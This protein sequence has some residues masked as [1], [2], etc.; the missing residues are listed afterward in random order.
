V[1]D[2]ARLVDNMHYV[3]SH[4]LLMDWASQLQRCVRASA[5]Y[6]RADAPV[7]RGTQSQLTTLLVEP[8]SQPQPLSA[9]C[10]SAN[11]GSEGRALSSPE[12]SRCPRSAP[13]R[14]GRASNASGV[15]GPVCVAPCSWPE[16]TLTFRTESEHCATVRA[17]SAP[18]S[19]HPCF[20]PERTCPPCPA[21]PPAVDV[22]I[23]AGEPAMADAQL[24][25]LAYEL[26]R[27]TWRASRPAR[28][29]WGAPRGGCW[30]SWDSRTYISHDR[31]WH[32]QAP[33]DVVEGACSF[34]WVC[35]RR[36]LSGRRLDVTARLA[37]GVPGC[38]LHPHS[39]RRT[40]VLS[41]LVTSS[42]SSV[43]VTRNVRAR[44]QHNPTPVSAS[45]SAP[46]PAAPR[47]IRRRRSSRRRGRRD[48][49]CAE[50]D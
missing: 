47:T 6:N 43:H 14:R 9:A 8:Q 12:S 38:Q 11:A 39:Q 2:L 41:P 45:R 49:G 18:T 35:A 36:G 19:H 22:R 40:W 4:T 5:A 31:C 42:A 37:C 26:E 7:T 15:S 46:I 24:R 44:R 10:I 27:G 25:T 50:G 17:L 30:P 13:L 23:S 3:F 21:R 34:Y 32:D 28:R 29:T 33:V 20:R 16:Q 1:P 48:A